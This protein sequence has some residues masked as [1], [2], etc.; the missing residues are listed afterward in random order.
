MGK[1]QI[2]LFEADSCTLL[3]KSGFVAR[4]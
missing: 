3:E 2:C 4:S 1:N